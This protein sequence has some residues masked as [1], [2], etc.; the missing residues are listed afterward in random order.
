MPL[1]LWWALSQSTTVKS[2]SLQPLLVSTLALSLKIKA[3]PTLEVFSSL[4]QL[5]H[6]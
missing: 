2:E 6:L 1:C 4:G 5:G 3:K